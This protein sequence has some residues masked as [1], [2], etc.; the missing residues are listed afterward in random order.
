MQNLMRRHKKFFLF[1]LIAFIGFPMLFF[2]IPSFFGQGMSPQQDLVL[3]TVG[4]VTVNATQFQRALDQEA[5]RRSQMT[6]ERPTFAE[7]AADGTADQVLQSLIDEAFI[8]IQEQRKGY[9]FQQHILEEQLKSLPDFRDAEGNFH[10]AAWNQWVTQSRGVDWNAVYADMRNSLTRE[11][12]INKVMAPATRILDRELE[13]ALMDN[14]T[15]IVIRYIR[16]E[17]PVELDDDAL[18]AHYE[19]NS[20]Q[21]MSL[22]QKTAEYAAI[23]LRPDPPEIALEVLERAQ[24]GEDFAELANTYS[25]I[26]ADNGGE[27]GWMREGSNEPEHRR[28]LYAL[29]PGEVSDLVPAAAGYY[30]YTIDE[31]RVDEDSGEREVFA[32][33]ILFRKELSLEERE[34]RTDQARTIAEAIETA[35]MDDAFAQIVAEHDLSVT[36]TGAFDNDSTEIDGVPVNDARSF[37]MAFQGR[38]PDD[39]SVEVITGQ[40]NVYVARIVDV[41]PGEVMPFEEVRE[42]VER[43]AIAAFERSEAYQELVADYVERIAEQAESLDDVAALFPELE[44]TPATTSD[45]NR[46]EFLFNEQVYLQTSEVYEAV[47]RGEPGA[48]AGPLQGF[49]GD[50]YF[51][52]LVERTPPDMDDPERWA[53]ELE[54][55]RAQMLNMYQ[56]AVLQDY[57]MDLR[58]RGMQQY[59]INTNPDVLQ[60]VLGLEQQQ[61]PMDDPAMDDMDFFEMDLDDMDDF[62]MELSLEE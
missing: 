54:E 57:L 46:Q 56:N 34:A 50:T 20:D 61:F 49:L 30:L 23:S 13:E 27:M 21:Y 38:D 4:N 51:I 15:R 1:F 25:D 36:T 42:A 22:D 32:R 40:E 9:S 5:N 26:T 2:G 48:F 41:V 18:L 59:P 33:Q 12:Y 37:R 31:E 10:A 53:D 60:A 3:A 47:G 35:E 19:E 43:D 7:L 62:D 17:P 16:V 45:F 52:E 8:R 14:E 39:F 11:L 58:E 28:P 29:E 44:V 6:G 24:A 55:L